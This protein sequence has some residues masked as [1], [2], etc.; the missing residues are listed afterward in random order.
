LRPAY[1]TETFVGAVRKD[2]APF[3]ASR[4]RVGKR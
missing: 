1:G 3:I 2:G 4:M